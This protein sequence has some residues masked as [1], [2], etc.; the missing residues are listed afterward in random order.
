[1]KKYPF[2][3]Q[4]G[5]KDCGVASLLMI[6]KYYNGSANANKLRLE[7]NTT[8]TGTT[9]LNLI[10]ASQNNGF[11]AFG[12]KLNNISHLKNITLPC[13]AHVK[14]EYGFYHFVVIYEIKR[15]ILIG[16]P[17]N[18]LHKLS[19]KEFNDNFTGNIISL[20]PRKKLE[21]KEEE[22]NLYKDVLT[23]YKK[24][25]VSIILLSLFYSL[26]IIFSSFYIKILID[27]VS[28][29]KE[30][31]NV[32]YITILFFII[33]MIVVLLNY[34][35]NKMINILN[36]K[37]DIELSMR[38]FNKIIHLPYRYYKNINVGEIISRF[39]D[40][41]KI[42]NFISNIF[43]LISV[44]GLLAI[45][46]YSFLLLISKDLTLILTFLVL[47]YISLFFLFKKASKKSISKVIV[48]EAKTSSYLV[49]SLENYESVYNLNNE[50]KVSNEF[51]HNY[52]K[53][54]QDYLDYQNLVLNKQTTSDLIEEI[55]SKIILILGFIL[56]I[57]NEMS[58]SNLI[59]Y[60]YLLIYFIKPFQNLIKLDSLFFDAKEANQRIIDLVNYDSK[61]KG[62]AL[63]KD[64]NKIN[65][66]NTSFSYNGITNIFENLSLEFKQ[67]HAYFIKGRSGSGKS[68][69][70]KLLKKD[71]LA[72]KGKIEVNNLNITN[73]SKEY[74]K[75]QIIYLS[76]NENLFTGTLLENLSTSTDVDLEK[77]KTKCQLTYVNK[78]LE[79]KNINYNAFIEE[80]AFN[81]SGGEKQRIVLTRS[82]MRNCNV[83]IIDEGLSEVDEKLE[84]LILQRI[85]KSY[86][87]KIFIYISHH[88]KNES[89]FSDVIDLKGDTNE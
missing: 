64:I 52:S 70:I 76:Q 63:K 5:A 50:E 81:F 33:G 17:A 26:L 45:M 16:D 83:L 13:I 89:L 58:L 57:N 84:K 21:K 4:Q 8:K 68:S 51:E 53:F 77:V 29:N 36:S 65:Y 49:E 37:I 19:T 46:S 35:R 40:L 6:I 15:K 54:I 23:K 12:V 3:K 27:I 88:N 20:Y 11:E 74:L 1:M 47:I 78:I 79:N 30:T 9:A 55:F 10:K 43:I 59:M 69:L 32:Y 34:I 56:I 67:G 48:S 7:T 73:I 31:I 66:N 60:N 75:E 2:V 38:V 61:E 85:I 22:I 72:T 87:N 80:G 24:S 44:D 41:Q 14:T 82:L 28:F 71:Y 42:R 86:K 39:K 25:I 62:N 18:K